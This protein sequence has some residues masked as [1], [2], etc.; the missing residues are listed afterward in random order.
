MLCFTGWLFFSLKFFGIVFV[1]PCCTE[2]SV[3]FAKYL[4]ISQ[5]HVAGFQI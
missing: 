3:I 5:L 1:S 2:S 4:P